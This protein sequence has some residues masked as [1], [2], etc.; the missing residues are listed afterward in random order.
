MI[1]KGKKLYFLESMMPEKEKH[2]LIGYTAEQLNWCET[3]EGEIWAFYNEKDLFYTKN[4]MEHKKH[5]D[6]GPQTSGMPKEAPGN[7]G[8]WIGWQIVNQYMK[9]ADG[10]VSLAMLLK[11]AFVSF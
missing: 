5:V 6:D 8:T 7:V 11:I 3:S 1:E 10:K 9:N 4:Y 2:I